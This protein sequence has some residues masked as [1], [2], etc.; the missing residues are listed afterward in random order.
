MS[1]P[2]LTGRRYSYVVWL[3]VDYM[4]AS[5]KLGQPYKIVLKES[6]LP[7]TV[8]RSSSKVAECVCGVEI[9][10]RSSVLSARMHYHSWVCKNN[11]ILFILFFSS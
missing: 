4:E 7:L 10:I 6:I 2:H 1:S 3:D 9:L 11:N 8:S 5:E